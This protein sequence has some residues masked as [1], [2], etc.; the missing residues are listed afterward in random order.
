MTRAG[1]DDPAAER[2]L[3]AEIAGFHDDP[4]GFVRFAF[5]WGEG[6]LAG[7]DGPDGWQRDLLAELG[8]ALRAGDGAQGALRFAVASGHGVGKGALSAWLILWAM[9]TRPHLNAIV[10]ANTEKQLSTK[11]WRELKLWHKRAINKHWFRP[12]AERFAAADHPDTWFT[13][14][15]TWS[16]QQPE[17]FAGLHGR[18]VLVIYDEASAIPDAIWEV[19]E[20]ATTTPGA[21]W[22]VFGNPTRSTG[23]FRD[24][25]ASVGGRFA[26][27]WRTAQVDSR[28]SRLASRA[29]L[30]Q[31]V[32]DY[33]EDSDFVRV[34][35]RGLFP[36]AGAEGFIPRDRVLAAVM[37]GREP[38]AEDRSGVAA[39][40]LGVDVARFGDDASVILC[41]RGAAIDGPVE[42]LVGLDTM[43]LADRV[44][45]AIDRLRPDA[46]FVD[47]VGV[48]GGVVDR[49]RQLGYRV[50]EANFGEKASR[51]DAFANRGAECWSRMRDW[52]ATA[53]LPDDPALVEELVG[54]EYGFDAM[55][56]LQLERKQDMKKRGL[57][58]PDA[59]DALALTF[60]QPVRP[61][62]SGARPVAAQTAFDVL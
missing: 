18:D 21:L 37:R 14:A 62:G 55:N 3:R 28:T 36:R 17:A 61:G 44:A 46:V 48:G 8:A 27:R 7:H 42:R 34:R 29:Q 54:R 38:D 59:A 53:A 47:G 5:A 41:R 57:G 25:F 35:V 16:L 32:A 58:S 23:R 6:P 24:C 26:H 49:L 30:D 22:F 15:V 10:T 52:L 2:A 4:L 12:T 19:T 50:I 51:P 20:G 1:A 33:G 60:Y 56:R 40:V 13:A 11:T 39:R 43:Q 9:S 45:G 31:W